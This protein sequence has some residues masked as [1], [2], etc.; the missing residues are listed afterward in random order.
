MCQVIKICDNTGFRFNVFSMFN[1]QLTFH[2]K[3]IYL[4][5]FDLLRMHFGAGVKVIHYSDT[6]GIVLLDNVNSK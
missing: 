6:F 5:I 2:N 1:P 3:A 4:T